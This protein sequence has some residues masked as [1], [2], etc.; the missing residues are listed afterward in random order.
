MVCLLRG[1][2]MD[3]RIYQ[4][5]NN[6]YNCYFRIPIGTAATIAEAQSKLTQLKHPTKCFC[7]VWHQYGDEYTLYDS[8]NVFV[9]HLDK[10]SQTTLKELPL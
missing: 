10:L 1:I 3:I 6:G 4:S 7:A 8:D 9:E 5:I 2:T